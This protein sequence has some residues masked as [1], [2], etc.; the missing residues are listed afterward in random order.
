MYG[1]KICFVGRG[2]SGKSTCL[3]LLAHALQRHGRQVCI[4]DCDSTNIGLHAALGIKHA[5]T[6]LTEYFGGMVFQGGLITCPVDDPGLIANADLD[7][8]QLPQKYYT[9]NASG[10]T[11]LQTG[12]LADY[13]VG[14]G[15]DGPMVKIARDLR[16]T[17]NKQALDLL[18]DF[19]AGLEDTSRGALVGMDAIIVVCDPS[20][21]AIE[22]V[23]SLNRVLEAQKAGSLPSTKHLESPELA[24]LM[25]N[26]YKAWKVG[27]IYV[28]L[29]KVPDPQT[30]DYL[31]GALHA[32]G[33]QIT[34]AV[35]DLSTIREAWLRALE[36]PADE[37]LFL[38]P[39][40]HQLPA[41]STEIPV[42]D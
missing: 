11:L 3:V 7:L 29:T 23:V 40:V 19:K 9:T 16:V 18:V 1:R 21:A 22:T 33:I 24:R 13:G 4:L 30:G 15:C 17:S 8:S 10:I 12:K 42:I 37:C 28:V 32:H 27:P 39:L 5:P 36:L 2:G 35:P 31:E 34:A 20:A 41:N 26:L 25:Q 14:A 6:P 38:D